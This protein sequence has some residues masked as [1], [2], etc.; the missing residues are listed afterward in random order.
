MTT[1]STAI[2]DPARRAWVKEYQAHI[3]A[4]KNRFL[5]GNE[6]EEENADDMDSI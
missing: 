4:N 3:L 5:G 2:E 6:E 1:D